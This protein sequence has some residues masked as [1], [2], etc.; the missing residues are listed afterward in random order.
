MTKFFVSLVS[1]V[2]RFLHARSQSR[3]M[4]RSEQRKRREIKYTCV[5]ELQEVLDPDDLRG[6]QEA[7]ENRKCRQRQPSFLR[8]ATEI[9]AVVERVILWQMGARPG[10]ALHRHNERIVLG[11]GFD[12]NLGALGEFCSRRQNDRAF[13]YFTIYTHGA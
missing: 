9:V 6:N 2:S 8:F 10:Q 13:D 5:G 11:D 7:R 4:N 12:L 3:R 1:L